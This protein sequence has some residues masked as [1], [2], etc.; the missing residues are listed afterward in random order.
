MEEDLQSVIAEFFAKEDTDWY[1]AGIHK[2]ISCYNKY[3]DEQGD[4][5]EKLEILW[6][7]Q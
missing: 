7:I 5:V 6:G 1:S 2:V 4:Y 3:P